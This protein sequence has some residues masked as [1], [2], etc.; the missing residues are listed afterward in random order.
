M[1]VDGFFDCDGVEV[2]CDIVVDCL[3]YVGVGGY[4][5]D[6]DGIYVVC[7]QDVCQFGVVKG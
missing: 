7:V 1:V 2:V 3:V 4:I 6:Q 5:G